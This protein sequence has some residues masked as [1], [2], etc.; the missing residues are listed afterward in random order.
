MA[1]VLVVEDDPATQE[2]LE[3]V[4]TTARHQV[5]VV[6]HP[7]AALTAIKRKPFDLILTD[8]FPSSRGHLTGNTGITELCIAAGTTPV[9]VLTAHAE[10]AQ[11]EPSVIGVCSILIKPFDL[12][13]L[14]TTVSQYAQYVGKGLPAARLKPVGA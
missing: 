8:L 11:W 4:L 3:L 6:D 14:L 1:R 2:V 12:A 10:A 13:A 7:T 5:R 9:I